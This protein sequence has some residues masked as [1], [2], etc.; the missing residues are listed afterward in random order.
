MPLLDF[1]FHF[2]E[3]FTA[4]HFEPRF[5]ELHAYDIDASVSSICFVVFLSMTI[6]IIIIFYSN[7]STII[8]IVI[9]ISIIIKNPSIYKP[10]PY[11]IIV[12]FVGP[13]VLISQT[14]VLYTSLNAFRSFF[15]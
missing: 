15:L 14:T 12:L 11:A 8:V 7:A 3:N 6:T 9:I 2:V 4:T 10:L 13:E 5:C 1:Q